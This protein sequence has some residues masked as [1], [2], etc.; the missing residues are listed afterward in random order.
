MCTFQGT[1]DPDAGSA[2]H[3]S[4]VGAVSSSEAA[5]PLGAYE[6]KYRVCV[7]QKYPYSCSQVTTG[8]WAI[9]CCAEMTNQPRHELAR[10]GFNCKLARC[11][12]DIK[13][14]LHITHVHICAVR[15]QNEAR[16]F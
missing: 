13:L 12:Y 5:L 6:R 8:R 16:A 2:E 11:W 10:F 1:E 9:T 7:G 3:F 4:S 14:D 15:T